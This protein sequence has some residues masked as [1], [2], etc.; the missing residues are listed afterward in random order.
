[1]DEVDQAL[2][3]FNQRLGQFTATGG[4]PAKN[5]F[6]QL[7]LGSQILSGELRGTED[8]LRASISILS[9][10][11]DPAER[12]ALAAGLFGREMGPQLAAL[13]SEG[14]AGIQALIDQAP[15]LTDAQTKAAREIEDA[16]QAMMANVR[17]SAQSFI[18]DM[19][20]TFGG[21]G[22]LAVTPGDLIGEAEL[23]SALEGAQAR[24]RELAAAFGE[25]SIEATVARQEVAQLRAEMDAMVK[26]RAKEQG[27]L[28][29]DIRK[30]AGFEPEDLPAS[31][32]AAPPPT[33]ADI[34]GPLEEENALLAEGLLDAAGG[35]EDPRGRKDPQARS[36]CRGGAAA[37]RAAGG[38]RRAG[39]AA[40]GD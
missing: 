37:H 23:I 11:S 26:G 17:T 13:L 30:G 31:A 36:D 3:R 38:Q 12:A 10:V 9:Q 28:E 40:A 34:I 35:P 18:I 29:V 19:I 27:F 1:M 22:G 5:A 8:A 14:E 20:R 39:G 25:T 16:W 33:F 6:T 7:G 32:A 2:R 21:G 24:A 4:G 15:L